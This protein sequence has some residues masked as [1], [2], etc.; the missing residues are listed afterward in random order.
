LANWTEVAEHVGT[1]IKDQCIEHYTNVYMNSPCFPEPDMSH[2]LGKNRKELLAMAKGQGDGK[3]GFPVIGDATPKEDSPFSS[4][5][6]KIEDGN[7]DVLLGRSSPSLNADGESGESKL[8]VNGCGSSSLPL[9]ANKKAANVM[10]IKDGSD[11]VKH[12]DF[13][14]NRSIG[15]KKPKYIVDEGPSL[16]ELSGYNPKRQEFDP[17]YD[18]DAEQLLADMEFKETDSEI[19]RN[20]KLRV[21][22]I[23]AS[24]LDERK[25]RKTFILERNLLF[26]NSFEKDLSPEEKAIY[27]R[28]KVFMRFHTLEEHELLMRSLIGEY[29]LRKRVQEL[30][31]AQVAGCCTRTEADAYLA[32]QAAKKL[33]NNNQVGSTKVFQR[34]N[35]AN[36][37]EYDGSSPGS[38][39]ENQKSKGVGGV[40]SNSRDSSSCITS[41]LED[42]D[43]VGLPEI[44]RAHV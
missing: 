20:V 30:Q 29:R 3:Q 13:H 36:K 25:R 11:R 6:V 1:K 26:P 12:E 44:G 2:V 24:R 40:E 37:G 16:T 35:L 7:R 9:G 14:G 5:K 41:C 4:S 32:R 34:G 22:Q 27:D 31:E 43:I 10:H 42:W 28:F 21:L 23:Y 17:E 38:V 18:N 33:N 39:G 19:E 8:G 15:G